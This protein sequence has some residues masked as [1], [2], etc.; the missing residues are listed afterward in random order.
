[1]EWMKMDL[2][3]PFK[4]GGAAESR[5]FSP[6]FRG[7]WFRCKIINMDVRKGH[8]ECQLEYIDYP[9]EKKSWTRLYKIR[10]G[11]RKQAFSQ[12]REIMVR[13]PFPQWYWEN[14]VSEC[15]QKTNVVAIVS[16]P[17]KVGD[18]V[19]WWYTGCYWTGKITELL[20]DDKVK[21]VLPEI[22]IGEG[23]SYVADCKDLRPALD[24]SL[25][26]GWSVPLSQ[27]DGK[28]WQTAHLSAQNADT[29]SSSSDEEIK[30]SYEGVQKSL[31]GAS[32]MP[33]EADS[34][35]NFSANN[36]DSHSMTNQTGGK[37]EPQK[38]LS[39]ACG[40]PSE[41]IN[42]K[43]L[44]PSQN[45]ECSRSNKTDS[46][47]V[48]PGS[49]LQADS[50]SQSSPSNFKRHKISTEHLVGPLPDT[51]DDAI[52]ELEKVAEKIRCSKDI[53]LSKCSAPSNTP[54]PFWKIQEKDASLKHD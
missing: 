2:I 34:C 15:G 27:G 11:C 37:E 28:C 54:K 49:P 24:W 23:G 9:D 51:F 13:P 42:S 41:N 29:G 36:N 22:P 4:V 48:R 16:G 50:N 31:N 18:L 26:K 30:E 6:G 46:V 19:D 40:M 32:D 17:W 21:I 14:Q 7:A 12:S 43:E 33:K 39:G 20:G 1:M 35:V 5:T 44:P 25:E 52:I 10:P 53:L 8:L 45:I 3:L 47:I 38:C